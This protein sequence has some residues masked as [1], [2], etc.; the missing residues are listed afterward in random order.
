MNVMHD[1]KHSRM[2]FFV[3]NIII[4]VCGCRPSLLFFGTFK[5]EIIAHS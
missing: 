4:F 2:V 3:F 5:N 1:L